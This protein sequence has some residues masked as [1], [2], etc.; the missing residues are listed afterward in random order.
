MGRPP[1]RSRVLAGYHAP[2]P[3]E[4]TSLVV[5]VTAFAGRLRFPL[6]FALTAALFVIDLLVPDALPFADEVLLGLGT[7]LLSR[8]KK[9][10]RAGTAAGRG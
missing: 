6:L 9:E 5:A 2:V 3:I 4:R 7:I 1:G 10:R 8:W